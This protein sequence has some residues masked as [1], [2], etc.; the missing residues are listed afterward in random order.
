MVGKI[1]LYG[2]VAV[3]I[4]IFLLFLPLPW[5]GLNYYNATVTT[6]VSETCVIFCSYSVQSVSGALT[7]PATVI[8]I[9]G[10]FGIGLSISPPCIS[11]SYKVTAT[12]S[13]GQSA[14]V[15]ESKFVSN[16]FNINY[17]DTLVLGLAYVPGGTY[18]ISVLVTLNGGSIATGSGTLVVP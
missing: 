17:Q 3:V 4:A 10:L 12:L 16:L 15:A 8:D 9:W 7:G 1:A 14:S 11:C 2:I 18:T 6:T 13:N 5:V